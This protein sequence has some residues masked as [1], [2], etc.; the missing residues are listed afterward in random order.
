MTIITIAAAGIATLH[1]SLSHTH[2]DA[3]AS[4]I[5]TSA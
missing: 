3:M 2:T 4:V 1:L 5:A